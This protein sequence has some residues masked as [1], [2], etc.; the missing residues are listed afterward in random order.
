MRCGLA[1][2][3]EAVSEILGSIVLVV[4]TGTTFPESDE[5][6]NGDDGEENNLVQ[7]E[8]WMGQ[9]SPV[10]GWSNEPLLVTIPTLLEKTC[11]RQ[12]NEMQTIAMNFRSL[13]SGF[14]ISGEA[15]RTMY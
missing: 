13:V 4:V 10:R 12:M 15:D 9:S 2:V 3:F 8:C 6:G 5:A 1:K 7:S 11:I 14:S